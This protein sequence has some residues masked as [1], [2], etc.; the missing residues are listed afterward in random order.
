MV[1]RHIR[2]AREQAGLTQ[3]QLADAAGLH[4]T[5]VSMLERDKRSPTLEV[6]FRISK[7][8]A[9]QPSK[10]LKRIEEGL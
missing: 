8:L 10:L 7:A 6:F 1:G 2:W 3:E 5:Y 4:R 9:I